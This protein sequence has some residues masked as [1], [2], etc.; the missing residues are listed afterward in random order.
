MYKEPV[1]D[2]IDPVFKERM[3]IM[4]YLVEERLKDVSKQMLLYKHNHPKEI[5]IINE[6]WEEH[7]QKE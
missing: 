1:A 7:G 5:K 2:E 3:V 6:V 4:Y